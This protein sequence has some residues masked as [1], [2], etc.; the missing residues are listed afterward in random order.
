[1]LV[2]LD[3]ST[4]ENVYRLVSEE[5]LYTRNAEKCKMWKTLCKSIEE[6]YERDFNKKLV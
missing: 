6:G 5:M 3:Q 1:M 4:A 2:Y